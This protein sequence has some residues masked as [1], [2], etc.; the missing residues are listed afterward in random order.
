MLVEG[1]KSVSLP[2]K[3]DHLERSLVVHLP[4]VVLLLD[5]V[6]KFMIR[7]R[8]V[9]LRMML[10]ES[11]VVP[12][13][14]LSGRVANTLKSGLLLFEEFDFGLLV[15]AR[16]DSALAQNLADVLLLFKLAQLVT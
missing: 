4:Q 8:V 5:I 6:D 10:V 11:L 12:P 14:S 16:Q 13:V 3:F 15:P 2:L 7:F 1:G 9:F